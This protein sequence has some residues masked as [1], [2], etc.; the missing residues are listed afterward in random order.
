MKQIFFLLLIIALF[1]PINPKEI[2]AKK[3]SDFNDS[4]ILNEVS[5]TKGGTLILA[6][7]SD[8]RTFNPLFASED[9]ASSYITNI[10]FEGLVS[11][12]LKTQEVNPAIAKEW[13]VSPD[14]KEW[15][16]YLRRSAKWS[17]GY[18]ITADDVIFTLETI[19][20]PNIATPSKDILQINHKKLKAIKINNYTVKIILP[21]IYAPFLRQM[22]KGSF[23][24]LPK[25]KWE[26]K[27]KN[28]SFS[29]EM[30][31]SSDPKDIVVSGP[32]MLEKYIPGQRVILKANPYFYK[33]DR[34]KVRLP[35][36]NKV[37]VNIISDYNSI[38]LKLISGE[39]DLWES[40]RAEDYSLLKSK[41]PEAGLKL[42]ILGI[43]AG[44]E[45]LWFNLN[46]DI[47]PKTN[48]N[49]LS[50][51]K[52]SWFSNLLFRKAIAYAINRESI[53]KNI[54][55]QSAKPA[56]GIE[57]ESNKLWHNPNLNTYNYDLEKSKKLL[58]EAGFKLIKENNKVKLI[59]KNGSEVKFNLITN[60]ENIARVNAA[61]FI[62]SDLKKI[63]IPVNVQPLEFRT[64]VAKLTE[65]YDYDA[66]LL[67]FTR[68]DLDPSSTMNFL[69]SSSSM[70]VWHPNQK[71]PATLWEKTIDELMNSQLNTYDLELRK[72]YYWEVQKIINEYLPVIYLYAPV[73]ISIHKKN[74]KNLKCSIIEPH[75]IW[76]IEEL[77]W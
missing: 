40:V 32:Y 17:D 7:I 30:S 76:N 36:F 33:F 18:S 38:Y 50:E 59:D 75:C 11:I 4:M 5:G 64:L 72:K 19:Y 3:E 35:Y 41:A 68:P 2:L 39:L 69:L 60:S 63:G 27:V 71:K 52:L 47:N 58:K 77:S 1:L 31:L 8:P 48:K 22:E 61:N 67:A 21:K 74:L 37:I 16:F 57:T 66:A 55:Y 73:S 9:Q 46:S 10:M 45:M 51:K 65:T 56:Y 15:T 44:P 13:K 42:E 24:I 20:N 49:Y 14:G 26:R 62:A 29:S 6:L 34:N 25:H 12:N 43:S 70:H 28:G 23:P 54:Y 53:I